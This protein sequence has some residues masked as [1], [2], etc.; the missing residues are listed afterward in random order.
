[1]NHDGPYIII[2]DW[3]LNNESYLHVSQKPPKY[4]SV[5][6]VYKNA[7]LKKKI[8]I[9]ALKFK[10]CALSFYR[11]LQFFKGMNLV[12]KIATTKQLSYYIT[13]KNCT[14]LKW[15]PSQRARVNSGKYDYSIPKDCALT[16][17]Y[18]LKIIRLTYNFKT[19]LLPLTNRI[20]G[21][22]MSNIKPMGNNFVTRF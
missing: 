1:M 9:L 6:F 16:L 4:T 12:K 17:T 5:C 11:P 22:N 21:I 2:F 7:L 18:D 13:S 20:L 19:N 3:I 15:W 8:Y 10:N 14:S